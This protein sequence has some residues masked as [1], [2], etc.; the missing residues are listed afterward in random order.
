[1]VVIY[2]REIQLKGVL[3]MSDKEFLVLLR[4]HPELWGLVL[5][6]LQDAEQGV[7]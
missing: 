7:A 2:G 6:T 1:M 5:R 3:K 4:E